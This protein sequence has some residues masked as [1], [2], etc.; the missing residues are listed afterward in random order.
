MPPKRKS[1]TRKRTVMKRKPATR[2][3]SMS[4]TRSRSR[5]RSVKRAPIRKVRR[6]SRVRRSRRSPS[7]SFEMPYNEESTMLEIPMQ[8]APVYEAPIYEHPMQEAP[9]YEAPMQEAPVQEPLPDIPQVQDTPLAEIPAL[10]EK[11]EVQLEEARPTKATG[12]KVVSALKYLGIPAVLA[13]SLWGANKFGA[14][15]LVRD[16]YTRI[17]HGGPDFW[18]QFRNRDRARARYENDF[19]GNDF[20]ESYLDRFRPS[21]YE[22]SRASVDAAYG[23]AGDGLRGRMK[24]KRKP[25]KWQMFVKKHSQAVMRKHPRFTLGQKMKLLGKMYKKK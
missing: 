10:V 21:S 24:S 4:R 1:V 16:L 5:S 13:A 17:A 23:P 22:T 6:A 15:Q 12:S 3:R 11:V 9:I 19:S 14:V 25:S 20:S 18:D 7:V 8:E 2:S